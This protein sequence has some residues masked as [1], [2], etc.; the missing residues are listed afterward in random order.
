MRTVASQAVSVYQTVESI[1]PGIV[2]H[3]ANIEHWIWVVN[4][5]RS[6]AWH[7]K[8][9]NILETVGRAVAPQVVPRRPK[10]AGKISVAKPYNA[11]E[12]DMFRQAAELEWP[13]NSGALRWLAGATM[14]GGLTGV[15]AEPLGPANVVA[16]GDGRL[17]VRVEGHNPRWVPIRAD[18]TDLVLEAIK[19][20]SGERFIS[21]TVYG[22]ASG[23]A[24]QLHV[25]G[26]GSLSLR[27]ARATWIAAQL[28]S[29]VSLRALRRICG[30]IHTD[31]LDALLRQVSDEMDDETA[32]LKGLAA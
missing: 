6:P 8:E 4:K 1:D 32:V 5:G 29:D 26:L 7:R 14:G 10:S 9:R 3:P 20:T 21:S 24:K 19:L 18:Y 23:L 27:R 22:S 11:V 31:T 30:P 15:D 17:K 28:K 13:S 16:V 2:M 12:E 25:E